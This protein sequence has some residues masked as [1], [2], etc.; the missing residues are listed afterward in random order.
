MNWLDSDARSI[1][2]TPD[3]DDFDSLLK[4]HEQPTEIS[5]NRN[6]RQEASAPAKRQV[7]ESSKRPC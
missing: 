5:N 1:N 4:A 6:E 7:R 3:M 2:E